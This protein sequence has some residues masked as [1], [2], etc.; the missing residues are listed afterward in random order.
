MYRGGWEGTEGRGRVAF[1]KDRGGEKK[2]K[3]R[4][5]GN[6]SECRCGLKKRG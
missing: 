3:E 4:G 6:L 1:K 2:K 5:D